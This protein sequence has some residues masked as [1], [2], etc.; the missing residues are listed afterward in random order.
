ML[1]KRTYLITDLNL[2][3]RGILGL[4]LGYFIFDF[5]FYCISFYRQFHPQNYPTLPWS[6]ADS[7]TTISSPAAAGSGTGTPPPPSAGPTKSSRATS[8]SRL[9]DHTHQKL[10]DSVHFIITHHRFGREINYPLR[11][12]RL[13]FVTAP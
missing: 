11:A 3:P 7:A 1:L 12:A 13:L 8:S 5:T 9:R 2:L 4:C 6:G 10:R